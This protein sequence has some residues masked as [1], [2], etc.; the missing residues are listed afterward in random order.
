MPSASVS[1]SP[2]SASATPSPSLSVGERH[3][4][5]SGPASPRGGG[6]I[7]RPLV[8]PA[9]HPAPRSAI[10]APITIT[11]CITTPSRFPGPEPNSDENRTALGRDDD[12][13]VARVQRGHAVADHDDPRAEDLGGRL[14]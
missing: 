7:P 1:P 3:S 6:S 9:L 2:S 8:R 4:T 11:R 13:D 12:V 10:A 14:G 5:G